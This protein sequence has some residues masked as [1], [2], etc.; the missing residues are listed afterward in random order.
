[1]TRLRNTIQSNSVAWL[2]LFIALG[3]SSYAALTPTVVRQQ[4]PHSSLDR[5]AQSTQ[6]TTGTVRAWAVVGSKGRVISGGG[7]PRATLTP[8]PGDYWVHWGVKLGSG[9]ATVAS[10][11]LQYSPRSMVPLGSSTSSAVA[12]PAGYA[13]THSYGGRHSPNQTNVLTFNQSG[14]PAPLGFDLT[15]VC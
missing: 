4:V 9:C 2:A 8:T 13:V 6:S 7:K 10:V 5:S 11:D 3:G 14:Q 1:M 12:V 15:V